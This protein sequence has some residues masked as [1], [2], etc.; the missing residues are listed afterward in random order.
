LSDSTLSALAQLPAG[1]FGRQDESDDG[2]FYA[3]ERLVTH[4]DDSAIAALTAHYRSVLPPGADVLDLMSSWVSH[5][6]VDLRLGEVVGQG[7]NH[8]ELE[9]NPRLTQ[10]LVHDLNR[11]PKLPLDDATFDAALCCVSVQYL[12]RPAEVFSDVRRML[13]PNSRAH[14]SISNRCFPTKAVRI[15][16][17]LDMQDRA[18]L[19]GLYLEAAGFH[20]IGG[21]VLADGINGDPLIVVSGTA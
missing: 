14:I 8:A 19:V 18:R 1:A 9:A 6:P 21:Q 17:G 12:V 5:L 15:W 20:D 11:S 16:L 7:M 2:R 4:I 3:P 13:R 10:H